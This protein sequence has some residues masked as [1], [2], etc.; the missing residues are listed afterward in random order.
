MSTPVTLPALGES[1]TEGTVT[2]WLKQVGDTVA[3]DEPLLEVSTDKVDTE[4]PSPVAGTLVE[5]TA[6]EDETVEI[7]AQLCVIGEAG[8]SG[9]QQAGGQAPA[10]EAPQ[11]A[12]AEEAP[13]QEAPAQ[14]QSVQEQSVQSEQEEAP[15]QAA[16]PS[17]PEQPAASG[18]GGGGSTSV[19]LPAL[20]E[21]VTEGTVTRWLKA[22]GDDVAVDEPLLE[23]STDKVD[24]EIPSPVAGTLLEIKAQEDETVE[25]GAELAVIGAAGSAPA[26]Q[27]PAA[28]APATPEP[29]PEPTREEAPAEQT[30]APEPPAE[31]APQPRQP[32]Q[33]AAAEPPAEVPPSPTVGAASGAGSDGG[34][35]TPLVRKMAA[36]HGVDLGS[37]KGS[38][39]GG[40]IRKQD[41][42]AAA[43]ANKPAAAPAAASPSAPAA[44]A[45]PST[46]SPL[47]GTTEKMSRLRKVIAT[48]MVESL[49]TS[50]QLTQVMEIDMTNVARLRE[51]AKEDF[52]AREGVKLTYLPFFAKAAI[53]ALKQHPKLNANIDTEAGE[54]T[55]FDRENIAFAVDTDR[56][57][58]TP[59]VKDAGDLSVAG[60]AKKIADLAE[61]TRTNKITPDD[62]TGG[63][64]TITNLGTFGAL[65]DTPII[66]QPQVAILGPGAVVKRPVVIDDPNL[67]ETIAVRY[68]VN[69]AL[70]YDH[71][72]VDGADAGRFL[73]DVKGRLEAAQ[74]EV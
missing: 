48:R 32:E 41:V 62:L 20:G 12:P 56:G 34:Y 46:P 40:R 53:D 15:Q 4:I 59:V 31:T 33:P 36:E 70:T 60:L 71:R 66:N 7:G 24:T 9:G 38:G 61:R 68:M 25:I 52:L 45:T 13:A 63:T 39:V 22:V 26:P 57:L 44:A 6:A 17:A 54:V 49:Q 55:Y 18:G 69:L 16:P 74:F 5:I 37:I 19:T 72:L 21:S 35:V 73:S 43:E 29:A 65:F 67:G 23:V 58:L 2:R 42:L 1:V 30:P 11:E 64:F 14:E 3:V 27:A 50:A 10:Q 8:E 28:E 51:S 47:R